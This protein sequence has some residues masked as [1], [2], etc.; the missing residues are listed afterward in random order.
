MSHQNKNNPR[1]VVQLTFSRDT[2]ELYTDN[3]RVISK[4]FVSYLRS[5]GEL[6]V[7]LA[8][9]QSGSHVSD[10]LLVRTLS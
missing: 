7:G 6:S 10:E 8:I 5:V 3:C 4:Q 2:K 9:N 1:S